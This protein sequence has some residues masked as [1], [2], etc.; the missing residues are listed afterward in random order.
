MRRHQNLVGSVKL[1]LAFCISLLCFQNY[2]LSQCI[3]GNCQNGYG[4]FRYK[5]GATYKGNFKDG[6]IYDQ[7]ILYFSNGD[8]YV[9]QWQNRKRHGKGKLL[10]ANGDA[11]QGNFAANK[12]HGHGLMEYADGAEY[13][14]N[15]DNNQITGNGIMVY[16][17]G[18]KY[19]GEWQNGK[20]HGTGKLILVNGKVQEGDWLEDAFQ[21]PAALILVDDNPSEFLDKNLRDCNKTHCENGSGIYEYADG[22]KYIGAF[23]NGSPEGQGTC[24]YANGDKYVGQWKNHAPH[25]EGV[26]NYTSGRRMAAIWSFGRPLRPLETLTEFEPSSVTIDKDNQVKIWAVVVGVSTYEH[27]P[28]LRFTDDDAYRFYAFL[29]SPEGGA[30]VNDQIQVLIDENATRN[31]I[32]TALQETLLKADKNDVIVFYFSGHGLE[33]SFIPVDYDGF[34][35]RLY[36]DEIKNIFNKSQAKHK[37]IFA[38]ACY[39]GSLLAM[40]SPTHQMMHK[41]YESFENTKGGLAFFTSSQ[42]E[43]I[44]LEDGGLRQGIFTHYLIRGLNGEADKDRNKIVTIEEIASFVRKNVQEYTAKVQTPVLT[45]KYDS[46]MPVA[47]IR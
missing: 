37:M 22:S 10:F 8:R 30:L 45:G 6:Q 40:K 16:A 28:T 33:G 29:K 20:R 5:S 19:E 7:G 4:T 1:Y 25:G 21:D 27:M 23:K 12:L 24:Y 2:V 34:N 9:G 38:D 11:Y 47:M 13:E 3:K 26:Y 35:N 18:D 31:N 43:E 46:R 39:S 17:N 44:S 36:H 15:W 14:G 41:Y 32:L 42:G